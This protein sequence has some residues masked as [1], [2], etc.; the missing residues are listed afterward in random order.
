MVNYLCLILSC[1][2]CR[3]GRLGCRCR[4]TLVTTAGDM[5]LAFLFR[6]VLL[7]QR[8]WEVGV[9][10]INGASLVSAGSGV[11]HRVG[12][13]ITSACGMRLRTTGGRVQPGSAADRVSSAS[14][15]R[16]ERSLGMTTSRSAN[17]NPKSKNAVTP[18]RKL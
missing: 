13:T 16:R 18:G 12:V 8:R 9:R 10:T 17:H 14:V 6:S 3:G 7:E 1:K 2:G 4:F 5:G 15:P 11:A